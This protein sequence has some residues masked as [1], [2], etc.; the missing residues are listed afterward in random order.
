VRKGGS[1][2]ERAFVD[3]QCA[4]RVVQEIINGFEKKF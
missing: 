4:R 2:A 3:G 1:L